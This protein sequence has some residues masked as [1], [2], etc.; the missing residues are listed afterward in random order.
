[1]HNKIKVVFWTFVAILVLLTITGSELKSEEKFKFGTWTYG[2]KAGQSQQDQEAFLNP[3]ADSLR[4][5]YLLD[6][7]SDSVR[8]GIL[9]A[10]NIRVIA[11]NFGEN[12]VAPSPTFFSY[13]HYNP[14][15]AEGNPG[16][17]DSLKHGDQGQAVQDGD[18]IAWKVTAGEDTAGLIQWG[19]D[20][21]QDLKFFG[22]ADEPWWI[23]YRVR[24]R[25]RTG[26]DPDTLF[27][28]TV[29]VLLVTKTHD[30]EVD[31]AAI[32]TLWDSDFP[33]T[34]NYI[35]EILIYNTER[36]CEKFDICDRKVYRIEFRIH[37][38]GR[39]DLYVDKVTLYDELGELVVT[40]QRDDR[41]IT[42]INTYFND[43]AVVD[44]WYMNEELHPGHDIDAFAPWR[45]VDSVLKSVNPEKRAIAALHYD[46]LATRYDVNLLEPYELHVDRY[47]L[48]GDIENLQTAWDSF[49]SRMNYW[50]RLSLEEG[51]DFS[52]TAQAHSIYQD[53]CDDP[54][55]PE[56]CWELKLKLPTPYEL[57]C[58]TNLALAY[59]AKGVLYWKYLDGVS[60]DDSSGCTTQV[61]IGLLDSDQNYTENW[62]WI[63][64]KI[65]PY[66]DFLGELFYSLNWQGAGFHENVATVTG[67]FIDSLKPAPGETLLTTYAEVGFFKDDA[68]TDYFML[69]NRQCLENEDQNMIV[70]IDNAK[71]GSEKMWYVIDQYSQDTTFTGAING[72]I[73]FTTHLEPGEGKLFKLAPFSDSAFHGSA[74]PLDWQGGIM[75]DGDITVDS[76]Q[77]LVILPPAEIT[78]YANTDVKG[79]WD[80]DGCDLIVYGGLRVIGK[81]TD[82]VMFTSTEGNPDDWVGI[83]ALDLASSNVVLSY[84]V[85]ENAHIGAD[86]NSPYPDTVVH[87]R[88]SNNRLY[89]IRWEND[90][91]GIISENQVSYN[92][93]SPMGSHGLGLFIIRNGMSSS[94]VTANVITNYWRGLWVEDCSTKVSLNTVSNASDFGVCVG[95]SYYTSFPSYVILDSISV[96]G[97]LDH[98]G[99]WAYWNSGHV[100]LNHCDL[101]PSAGHGPPYGV[102]FDNDLVDSIYFMRSCKITNF[103]LCGIYSNWTNTTLDL[104]TTDEQGYNKIYSD[105]D[106]AWYVNRQQKGLTPIY[107]QYNWWGEYPPDSGRFKGN[108]LFMPA[109]RYEQPDTS[110]QKVAAFEQAPRV[111]EFVQNYPNPFNPTTSIRFSIGSHHS[112]TPTTLRIYNILGQ[113]V[114]TLVDEEKA[115]GSYTVFWDG[116]NDDGKM[117]SSGIYFYKL[118]VGEFSE[119]KKMV[120]LR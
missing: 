50:K 98:C 39:R 54:C 26:A 112:S 53:T 45:H 113:L 71:M 84:C 103:T 88:F 68:D 94:P 5:N 76:G 27:D 96:T 28:D 7:S 65:G 82:S 74:R 102:A 87:S 19:P 83:R 32:D 63:K 42:H 24:Y 101:L 56:S 92:T 47:P 116:L 29:A 6:K 117:V 37:W 16:Y 95:E 41:I 2:A 73:P 14:W 57:E 52:I 85:V 111:F 105:V 8:V 108:I 115:E 43:S 100:E 36:F 23:D 62:H 66:V 77:T 114:R 99:Y 35:Q 9:T 60:I 55:G 93:A 20:Y 70:Y 118:E 97:E 25:M 109:L 89:G 75:V 38:F 59:G 15:E 106:T 33:D 40:G 67:S 61:I 79:T 13:A 120:L 78:F 22:T 46:T 90:D 119:V 44:A 58:E 72:S 91:E 48:E 30:S 17:I 104:G 64:E 12:Y 34:V 1:M 86:L 107:A 21:G 18:V 3:L 10:L 11:N 31:T 51:I 49:T 69:V 80:P 81:E 4:F 110:Q